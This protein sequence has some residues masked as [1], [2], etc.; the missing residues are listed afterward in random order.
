MVFARTAAMAFNRYADR[1]IDSINA[2][3]KSREIPSGVISPAAALALV[4]ISSSLFIIT[5]Y[6]INR[7]CF[8]LSPVAMAVV[9]GYSLTKRYTWL[10]HFILGLGLS[11]API[12]AYLAITGEFN[13]VPLFFSFAVLTW[14]SGFDIIYALQDEEFDKSQNLYSIPALLG[15]K[16]ALHVSQAAHIISALCIVAAG[17]FSHFGIIYWIGAA[18]FASLLVYQHS[19]VKPDDLSKVNIA[20]FT[21]NGIASIVFAAFVV[22]EIISK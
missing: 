20:F 17:V 8:Y 7:I 22:T 1:S 2:R 6:F 4:I 15:K 18:V 16:K 10:C 9:L 21:T 14:V 5:T 13:I 19:L 12:G 3:T 11:L